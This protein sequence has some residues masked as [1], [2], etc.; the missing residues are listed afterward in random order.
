MSLHAACLVLLEGH[1]EGALS[2]LG[3]LVRNEYFI[4]VLKHVCAE[5]VKKE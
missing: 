1:L 4:Q 2:L 3:I 5:R